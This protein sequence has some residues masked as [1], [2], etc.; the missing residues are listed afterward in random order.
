MNLLRVIYTSN[1]TFSLLSRSLL[2]VKVGASCKQELL[3]ICEQA[4]I[5]VAEMLVTTVFPNILTYMKA[6]ELT[7]YFASILTCMI[8][9]ELTS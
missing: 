3:T 7:S 5:V 1:F 8:Y 9:S 6:S 4:Y 2:A